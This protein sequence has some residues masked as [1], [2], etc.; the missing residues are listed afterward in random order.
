MIKYHNQLLESLH[1]QAIIKIY[2]VKAKKYNALDQDNLTAEGVA[3]IQ[4]ESF[5]HF[6]SQEFQNHQESHF[7]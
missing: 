6:L 2:L 7:F 4:A 5:R 3:S 1:E